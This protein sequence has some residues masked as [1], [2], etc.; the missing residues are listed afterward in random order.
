M[1]TFERLE[2]QLPNAL[3]HLHN[4]DYQP[5]E[6]LCDVLGCD[7]QNGPVP[8][9]SAII[10]EIEGLQP[11]PD[12]PRGAHGR[13]VYDVMYHRYVLKLTLEETAELLSLSV[14]HLTR[15]QRDAVHTLAR[16]LWERSRAREQLADTRTE[17][18]GTLPQGEKTLDTQALDWSSQAQR[19]L[20][21]LQVGAPDAVSDVGATI[22][23]VLKLGN[24][25]TSK[26]GV[27]IEVKF[28]HPTWSQRFTL[29]CC[30]KY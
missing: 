27:R 19:E 22:E 10:Q 12:I 20:A 24:V 25:L 30:A 5:S 7:P 15:I 16:I 17:R 26:R 11:N 8:V 4:R 9:Q 6:L 18:S 21:S 3:T 2:E 13:R 23:G 14:R 29:R 1:D 28:V